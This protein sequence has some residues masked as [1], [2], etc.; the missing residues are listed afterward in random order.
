MHVYL[1]FVISGNRS[2]VGC[3]AVLLPVQ[4]GDAVPEEAKSDVDE[5]WEHD[6]S[7]RARGPLPAPRPPEWARLGA[8]PGGRARFCVHTH[9]HARQDESQL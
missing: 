6:V 5:G 7:G 4:V 1:S 2:V 8:E 9:S 3:L